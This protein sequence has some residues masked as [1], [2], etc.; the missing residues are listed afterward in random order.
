MALPNRNLDDLILAVQDLK[1]AVDSQKEAV[2]EYRYT[3]D[4]Y[5]VVSSA[6][7]KP[8]VTL[9]TENNYKILIKNDGESYLYFSLSNELF[10]KSAW[11]IPPGK[12]MTIDCK[13]TDL[14]VTSPSD[15]SAWITILSDVINPLKGDEMPIPLNIELKI[16]TGTDLGT[17]IPLAVFTRYF[18]DWEDIIVG[19]VDSDQ[20]LTGGKIAQLTSY[21]PKNDY[22]FNVIMKS[23]HTVN[24]G[25]D[26]IYQLADGSNASGVMTVHLLDFSYVSLIIDAAVAVM[27]GVSSNDLQK[28]VSEIAGSI[29]RKENRVGIFPSIGGTFSISPGN[30][31]NILIFSIHTLNDGWQT[32]VIESFDPATNT[33][34]LSGY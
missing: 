4:N 33:F 28:A 7:W 11:E 20:G 12:G 15:G 13:T 1:L 14:W 6:T 30:K 18:S 9:Q 3:W 32:A 16:K 19:L 23:D 10:F 25:Q 34:V 2:V 17:D 24:F 21:Q 5:P 29:K 26:I 22:D 27:R 31:D 8:A